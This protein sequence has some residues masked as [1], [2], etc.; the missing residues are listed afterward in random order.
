MVHLNRHYSL[1][2][3]WSPIARFV[4]L[5]EAGGALPAEQ[6][7]QR[8]KQRTDLAILGILKGLGSEKI[9]SPSPSHRM[10]MAR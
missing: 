6:F 5:N 8:L 4:R 2:Q 7:V 10:D 3:L 9:G 1:V